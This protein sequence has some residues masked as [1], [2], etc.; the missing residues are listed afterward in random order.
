ML[1]GLGVRTAARAGSLVAVGC[2][3]V[4]ASGRVLLAPAGAAGAVSGVA[5]VVAGVAGSPEETPV[6]KSP[7]EVS[8]STERSRKYCSAAA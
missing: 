8:G 1:G 3:V 2:A 6:P 4:V 5:C 7:V